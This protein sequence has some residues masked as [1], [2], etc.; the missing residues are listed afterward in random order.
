LAFGKHTPEQLVALEATFLRVTKSIGDFFDAM[1]GGIANAASIAWENIKAGA[2]D[3]VNALSTPLRL[4]GQLLGM[5][6]E[7]MKV[8]W[9]A[10]GAPDAPAVVKKKVFDAR[11]S[12]DAANLLTGQGQYDPSN[13]YAPAPVNGGDA[14][15]T[16]NLSGNPSPET[17]KYTT[18][19]AKNAAADLLGKTNKPLAY[20]NVRGGY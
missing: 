1:F 18:A 20:G 3:L 15:V 9:G 5:G 8:D 14:N 17:V 2:A 12:V 13:P 19:E 16:I 7:F 11:D 6:E 4:V 10:Y